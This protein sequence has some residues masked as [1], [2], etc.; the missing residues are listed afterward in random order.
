M[1]ALGNNIRVKPHAKESVRP[2]GIII[3]DTATESN[4]EY[5]TVLGVSGEVDLKEGDEVLYFNS[6]CFEKDGEKIVD[7][8]KLIYFNENP[9]KGKVL[10][11]VI[12]NSDSEII[13]VS[14]KNE[15]V[16][17]DVNEGEEVGVG[18]V[19]VFGASKTKVNIKGKDLLL[20]SINNIHYIK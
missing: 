8:K 11:D 18:D 15:G 13:L 17:W 12:D 10:V 20:M 2:S 14:E 19:V 9:L 3:P 7:H 4:Q 5:G 1:K 16:V 6:K